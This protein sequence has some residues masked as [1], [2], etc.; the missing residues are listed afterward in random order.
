MKSTLMKTLVQAVNNMIH[1]H[2]LF[3]EM[4]LYSTEGTAI[5]L[6]DMA[7]TVDRDVAYSGEGVWALI[8]MFHWM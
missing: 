2:A 6:T 7:D 1:Y 3:I 4:K 8:S 5:Q